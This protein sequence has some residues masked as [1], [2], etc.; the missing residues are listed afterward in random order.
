MYNLAVKRG[1]AV[2]NGNAHRRE[3]KGAPLLNILRQRADAL[4]QPFV[5]ME[6]AQ[7]TSRMDYACV[8]FSPLRCADVEQLSAMRGRCVELLEPAHRELFKE[9]QTPL[10]MAD[11]ADLRVLPIWSLLPQ[12]VRFECNRIHRKI[13]KDFVASLAAE[14]IEK[15]HPCNTFQCSS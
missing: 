7:A 14:F 8:D 3:R 9:L 10:L 1:F 6:K 12:L 2:T 4:A 15:R 5:W 11:I 13:C